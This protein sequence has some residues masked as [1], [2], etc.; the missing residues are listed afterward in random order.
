MTETEKL[1]VKDATLIASCGL[2]C[3]TCN[4]YKNGKC[5]GCKEN[6]K[7]TWC[8][9]R[10]CN[11]EHGFDNCSQCTITSADECKKIN[12]FIGKVFGLVFKTDRL[13]S[14][15]YINKNGAES[16]VEKMV[17]L[18]QMAIKKGQTI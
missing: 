9:I 3:G 1:P 13:A 12:N 15:Q 2:Y 4:K 10:T 8:K 11:I 17:N 6:T 16:Y 14:L 18:G 7:A 5:L